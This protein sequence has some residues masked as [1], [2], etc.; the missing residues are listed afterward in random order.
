MAAPLPQAGA[1]AGSHSLRERT[2]PLSPGES[3][4][5]PSLR[6]LTN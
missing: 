6:K 2:Q 1:C 4:A 3:L 5:Q